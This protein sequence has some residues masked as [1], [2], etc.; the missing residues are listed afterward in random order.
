MKRPLS[1]LGI[2]LIVLGVLLVLFVPAAWLRTPASDAPTIRVMIPEG[3][4]ARD[5]A[6]LLVERKLLSTSIGYRVYSLLNV[7]ARHPKSGAYDVVFGSSY[8]TIAR[9]FNVGPA[10]EEV[11]VRVLEGWTIAHIRNQIK[12][13]GATSTLADFLVDDVR[14]SRPFLRDLPSGTSLEG[15]LFPDTYRVWGDQLPHSLITKQL[16]AFVTKTTGFAEEA[17]KQGR[18]LHEVVILASIVEREALYDADR[19]LVAG[20][21]MNRL[22]DGMRLQSDAT[23][24]YVLPNGRARLTSADLQNPSPYNS[25]MY[26]GLPPGPISNPSLAS[27]K[28][29]LHPAKTSYYFFLS[30]ANGKMYY[31]KNHAEHLKNRYTAYGE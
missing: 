2:G 20:I 23:L 13:Q 8:R 22:K 25:Y 1:V 26:E 12:Q 5:V 9:S 6:S 19:A 15:Y 4:T 31:A 24:N 3:S 16:D 10:R 27:L 28:A 11:S 18:S 17:Q 7:Q 21:F 29:A 14:S 30:D